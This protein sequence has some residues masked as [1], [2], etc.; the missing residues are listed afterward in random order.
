MSIKFAF[1]SIVDVKFIRVENV[2]D[3]QIQSSSPQSWLA[4]EIL[5]S[6]IA[7]LAH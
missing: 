5:K 7:I 3:L 6:A 2:K 1:L 4:M